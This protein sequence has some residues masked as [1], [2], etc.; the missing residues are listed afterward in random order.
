MK[1]NYPCDLSSTLPD[2]IFIFNPIS[3]G[4]PVSTFS[5][6][7][8]R[9]FAPPSRQSIL[10]SPSPEIQWDSFTDNRDPSERVPGL[11]APIVQSTL[12]PEAL[13]S[14][15]PDNLSLR[16]AMHLLRSLDAWKEHMLIP[17]HDIPKFFARGTSRRMIKHHSRM[18]H[19]RVVRDV[20][21]SD[22]KVV[23]N[24]FCVDKK[25]KTLRLVVDGRKVNVLMER[26]P[27][28]DLPSLHSVIDYLMSN[29]YALQVD[30][31]SFFY[32]F[33]ISEEVGTMFCANLAAERGRFTPVAL[34]RM[35]MGWSYAPYIA[36]L[37]SN[38][39][40]R[41]RDGR[42]LG[43][44]WIDNFTI[45]GKTK[46]EVM[47]NFLEFRD[48]CDAC[49][50][51]I[52]DR[53]PEPETVLNAL[54]LFFDLSSKELML[55]PAWVGKQDLSLA[56]EMT[57]RHLYMITGSGIWHDF[58]KH[59]PLCHRDAS[60]DV[61]RRVASL[62][63]DT[64]SWD[65]PIPFS[66]AELTALRTWVGDLI[67]NEPVTWI[68]RPE[69][70]LD[71]W[72]DASDSA[73]AALWFHEGAIAAG[74]QG[75]F[76]SEQSNWHIF[77]KEAFAA[78]RVLSASRGIPRAINIDNKPLVQC[79]HRGY[80]TN[81]FVNS[82]IKSWDLENITAQ[83]IPT[84]IQKADPYTRGLTFSPTLPPFCNFSLRRPKGPTHNTF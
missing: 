3:G 75:T 37:T 58:A 5:Q 38:T 56:A 18:L 12:D 47:A 46:E 8:E 53:N 4:S 50:V 2:D 45:S 44:A 60:M 34:T 28:M 62:V 84:T 69:P 73:W 22:I 39:L 25:D 21:Q 24:F 43:I 55:D 79:I 11:L 80:S 77:L 35:P 64:K 14:L 74:E 66:T 30:G 52:D 19:Y 54:G 83:W 40:L 68:P 17:F 78:N 31:T 10:Y 63:H 26:P 16:H 6:S 32:Q 42:V 20:R 51:Q 65:T 82:L 13:C 67:K 59:L 70:Q 57:P 33:G 27:R 71:L 23:T 76:T 29:A 1:V 49:N 48:R 36:Q 9:R 61:V 81:R 41:G 7:G 15:D 72:S